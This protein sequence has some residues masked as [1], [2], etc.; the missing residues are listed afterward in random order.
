MR[1]KSLIFMIGLILFSLD[2]FT[3]VFAKNNNI[4][5]YASCNDRKIYKIDARTGDILSISK[6]FEEMGYPTCMDVS[7]DGKYLYIGSRMGQGQMDYYPLVIIDLQSMKMIKKFKYLDEEDRMKRKKYDEEKTKNPDPTKL[8]RKFVGISA[9]YNLKVSPNS[10][11]IYLNY[12]NM[13][14]IKKIVK[15]NIGSE[16]IIQTID[17]PFQDG[18]WSLSDDEKYLEILKKDRIVKYN[19]ETSKKISENNTGELFFKKQGLNLTSKEIKAPLCYIP[20]K[21]NKSKII[22]IN[23]SSGNKVWD[24]KIHIVSD[25]EYPTLSADGS[26]AVVTSDDLKILLI[27][28]LEKKDIKLLKL[29]FETKCVL[30]PKY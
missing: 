19:L 26:I 29:D 9:I 30:Y 22:C 2:N 20:Y 18:Y 7:K 8:F 15:F 16:K 3:N 10:E 17:I 1:F 6:P 11:N 12:G 21:E 24:K 13:K 25:S 5:C 28:L 23:R 27:N 14:Y 4:Y